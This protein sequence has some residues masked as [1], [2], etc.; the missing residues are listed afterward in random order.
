MRKLLIATTVLVCLAAPSAASAA[1]APSDF[2]GVVAGKYDPTGADFDRMGRGK[3]GSLR[4]N[5]A[6]AS[7]QSSASAPYD[8]SRYDAL[9]GQAAQ[10]GIEVLATF[11]GTPGFAAARPNYPPDKSHID[12][13]EAFMRAAVERYGPNGTFWTLNPFLP[14]SPV[15]TWQLFNESNSPSYWLPKPRAKQYRPYLEAA[16]RAVKGADPGAKLILAGLFMTPRIKHAVTLVKY[17]TDLYRLKTR[18]LFDA[19]AVHP[20]STTPRQALEAVKDVRALMA[21]FK[22]K[23]KPIYLTEVGWASA[24]QKTPLTVKPKTQARYVRQTYGLTAAN[25]NKLKI[26]GVYW[27]TLKDLPSRIWINNTGLL[28]TDGSPKASWSAFVGLTGGTL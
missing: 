19:V 23:S 12:E 4:V 3:V 27:Y 8:W 20:Y 18:S 24:G 26:A 25:R 13:F 9:I 11:Y 6:W 5:V 15:T 28:T 22:D 17:L 10:Q 1:A 2:Y 14:K 7:V 16:N 21:R